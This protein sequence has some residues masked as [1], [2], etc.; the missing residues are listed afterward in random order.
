MKRRLK[1]NL[2]QKDVARHLKVDEMTIVNWEN[3]ATQ[4]TVHCIPRISSFLECIPELPPPN[5]LG[6]KFI[7]YRKLKGLS[8]KKFAAIF[9][10]DPSTLSQLERGGGKPSAITLTRLNKFFQ[11]IEVLR[12]IIGK[13][14]INCLN[15]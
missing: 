8:Q 15:V 5:S 3:G 10:I 12:L 13:N 2:F 7:Q 6:E 14:V 11:T 9:R 4:P 1:F